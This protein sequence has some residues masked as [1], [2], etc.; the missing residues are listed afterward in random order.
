MNLEIIL[1][2]ARD[3][4]HRILN[5]ERNKTHQDSIQHQGGMHTSLMQ[6]AMRRIERPL[7][8]LMPNRS[9][10]QGSRSNPRQSS[11]SPKGAARKR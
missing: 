10:K 7:V 5:T 11:T 6:R 4:L 1:K 9:S 8:K 2:N 3:N